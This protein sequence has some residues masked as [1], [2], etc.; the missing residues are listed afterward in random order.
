MSDVERLKAREL[1]YKKSVAEGFNID[2]I[3]TELS[4]LQSE[5]DDV[6]YFADGDMDELVE[7]LNVLPDRVWIE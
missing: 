5:M 4:E 2:N 7:A 6:R 3:R 1:R